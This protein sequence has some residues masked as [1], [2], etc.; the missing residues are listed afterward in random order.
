MGKLKNYYIDLENQRDDL[1]QQR[2]SS[3][4][5][6]LNVITIERKLTSVKKKIHSLSRSNI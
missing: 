5:N 4:K 1:I 2:D 3:R 6:K